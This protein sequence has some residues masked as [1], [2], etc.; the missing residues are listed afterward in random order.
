M[1]INDRLREKELRVRSD[2]ANKKA[3]DKTYTESMRYFYFYL[4]DGKCPSEPHLQAFRIREDKIQN[5]ILEATLFADSKYEDIE[6]VFGLSKDI[7]DIFKELFFDT[8]VFTS[9]LEKISYLERCKDPVEKEL[10]LRASSLGPD[11]IFF[12]YGDK[13][14]SEEVQ[15]NLIRKLCMAAAYKAMSMQYNSMTS[16]ITKHSVEFAKLTLKAFET[17]EKYTPKDNT[18]STELNRYLLVDYSSALG[19]NPENLDEDII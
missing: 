3:P 14:P 13:I 10:K 16:N 7:V 12:N 1:L 4:T 19:D 18:D 17:L 8:S 9:K 5:I 11:F 2:A 6:L 15:K